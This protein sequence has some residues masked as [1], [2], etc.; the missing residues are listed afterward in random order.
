VSEVKLGLIELPVRRIVGNKESGRNSAFANNFMPLLEEGTEFA[1][2]WSNLYDSFLK[3]G[4]RDAIKVYEFMNDYYVQEGN[5]RVSVSKF[6]DM[7][8]ILAD[9]RRLLP[10]PN[11]SKEY[12]VYSEYLDFYTSTKNVYIIFATSGMLADEALKAAVK[13]PGVKILCC[14]V[15]QGHTSLRYYFGK[16]YEATFLMGVLAADKLLLDGDGGQRKIGYIVRD[17]ERFNCRGL[18]AFALGVSLIDPEAKVLLELA[19][20]R[21]DTEIIDGWKQQ[22]VKY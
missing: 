20:D 7:E 19:Q 5:K 15:A 1:V 11:D 17:R 3:E 16:L 9:V 8:F 2:K 21:S 22:G 14:S 13:N 10:K 12:K 6:G 18:N 4:I